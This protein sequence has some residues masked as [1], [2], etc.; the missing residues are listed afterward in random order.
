MSRSTEEWA[1]TYRSML[2]AELLQLAEEPE[3]LVPEARSALLMELKER[4]ITLKEATVQDGTDQ[5]SEAAPEASDLPSWGLMGGAPAQPSS[6]SESVTI[7]S[8]DSVASAEKIQ[9]LLRNAGIDTTLEIIV[10]VPH[11]LSEKAFE[12]LDENLAA[13]AEDD[14]PDDEN[15]D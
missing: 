10:L 11:L 7:Y 14:N 9:L 2:D 1:D 13:P 6:P 8:A 5:P 3:D 4:G 12:L 15:E